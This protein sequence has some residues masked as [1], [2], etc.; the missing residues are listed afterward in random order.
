MGHLLIGGI[1]GLAF[2]AVF[3]LFSYFVILGQSPGHWA[4]KVIGAWL[5]GDLLATIAWNIIKRF[6]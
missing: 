3:W 1:G 4:L 6:K 2:R 5:I